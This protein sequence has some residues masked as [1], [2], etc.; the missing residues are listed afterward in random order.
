[1]RSTELCPARDT[2]LIR[3]IKQIFG[4]TAAR[5]GKQV[6]ML[7]RFSEQDITAKGC[8]FPRANLAG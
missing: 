3:W 6:A 7:L 5:F 2:I 1:M 8:V 4:E